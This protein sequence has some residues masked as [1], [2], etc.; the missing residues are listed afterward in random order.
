MTAIGTP[1]SSARL[2]A[3]ASRHRTWSDSFIAGTLS[4]CQRLYD[5]PPIRRRA[6][7]LNA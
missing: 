4:L 2:T 5:R 6:I 1:T 3:L 7:R